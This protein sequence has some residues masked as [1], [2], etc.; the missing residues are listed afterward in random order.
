MLLRQQL[1]LFGKAARATAESPLRYLTFVGD[2]LRPLADYFI[3]RPGRPRN[4]WTRMVLN[5]AL[6]LT[7]SMDTLVGLVGDQHIWQSFI[8]RSL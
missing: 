5:E 6:R 3:R 8:Q 7:G 1:L 4:E 2:S